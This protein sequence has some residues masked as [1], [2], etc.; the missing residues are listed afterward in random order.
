MRIDLFFAETDAG[1]YTFCLAE[2]CARLLDLTAPNGRGLDLNNFAERA[3]VS[4][5]A[6]SKNLEPTVNHLH[7]M[8]SQLILV[9]IGVLLW[10]KK[11][12]IRRFTSVNRF[13]FAVNGNFLVLDLPLDLGLVVSVTHSYVFRS[14]E[15]SVLSK[16]IARK[17][18]SSFRSRGHF[19]N[20]R[21]AV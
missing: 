1:T 3:R 21:L 12:L 17:Q 2:A 9:F 19:A 11:I 20:S 5:S 16:F 18:A 13:F 15:H 4:P 10:M 8:N 14:M 6:T 7:P